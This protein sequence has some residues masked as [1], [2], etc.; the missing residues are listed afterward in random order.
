MKQ[1]SSSFDLINNIDNDNTI[2]LY[3]NS[4]IFTSP[5]G[6]DFSDKNSSQDEK[7]FEFFNDNKEYADCSRIQPLN[8]EE[9]REREISLE[10]TTLK[11]PKFEIDCF[12]KGRKR[13]KPDGDKRTY[14]NKYKESHDKFNA[15]NIMRK[16]K[17]NLFDYLILKL[18]ESLRK[19]EDQFIKL[20]PEISENLKK[21]FNEELMKR[22][23]QDIIFNSKINNKYKNKKD[24]NKILINTIIEQNRE[25]KV[26]NLFSLKF[27]DFIND[28]KND[29]DNLEDFLEKIKFKENRVKQ[30]ENMNR[31]KY[32]QKLKELFLK[33]E[34]WFNN[35]KGR[36]GKKIIKK[37]DNLE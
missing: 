15:D 16:I 27:I 18:N 34:N 4:S 12:K 36:S 37:Q 2:G 7:S 17:S 9:Q 25:N 19:K 30:H 8:I 33:Y 21:D 13:L 1:Y 5:F 32:M 35:K 22:T 26:L 31:D 28:I 11:T 14:C 10:K 3:E 24:S 6:K 23:I 20:H 29:E